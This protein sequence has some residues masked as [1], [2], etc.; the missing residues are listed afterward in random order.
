VA[1]RTVRTQDRDQ[2][3]KF[4]GW[5]SIALGTAQV[6]AP[7]AMCRLVG[8]SVKGSAPRIMRLMGARELTSGIG[9][10]T[11]PRPTGWLWSR[12]GGDALD[13]SGLGLV[14]AKNRQV[15]TAFAIANVVGI[16]V[17]DVL[18]SVRLLR[19]SG[20]PRSG[21]RMR[22][23]VTINKPREQVEHAF[24]E[25][26]ELRKAVSDAGATVHYQP[27]PGDRGTEVVVAWLEDPPA[28]ELGALAKKLSGNDLATQLADDLRRFKALL[29]T[30]EVIRSDSTPEGH[31]LGRQLKQ[32]PAQ[33]LE[34]AIR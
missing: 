3:A 25:S 17:P 15:R 20:P 28:G 8:A 18:E 7:R 22:K 27:A 21:K 24:N 30:G 23:A 9:I 2:L 10:L 34:E 1:V 32:R 5:F 4:L 13:L 16:A 11:R 29:E 6:T 19:K 26:D 33:P 14:A 31:Q 12:V